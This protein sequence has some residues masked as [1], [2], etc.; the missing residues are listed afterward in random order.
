M[1]LQLKS[2]DKI[3]QL[4]HVLFLKDMAGV[5]AYMKKHRDIIKPKFDLIDM[6]L[7]EELD[8]LEIAK[9][10]NPKGGYFINLELKNGMALRVWELCKS[11]GVMIT[12][13]GS[14][15]PYGRDEEDKY[16]RLEPTYPPMN[17]LKKAV[18]LLCLA[19]KIAYCEK[20]G[21]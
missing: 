4:R 9:W 1:L 5:H 8:E 18:R 12:P 16:L 11:A 20:F 3:N 14:T 10:E 2:G 7:H 13:D 21:I 15:F 19:I 17:E 6:I